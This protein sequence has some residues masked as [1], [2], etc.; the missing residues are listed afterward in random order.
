MDCVDWVYL[1]QDR[2]Q[3]LPAMSIL[4]NPEVKQSHNTPMVGQGGE[5]V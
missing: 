4:L 5:D 2:N 3:L 1:A